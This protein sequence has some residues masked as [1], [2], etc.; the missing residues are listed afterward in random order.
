M[1]KLITTGL[2]KENLFQKLLTKDSV[3]VLTNQVFKCFKIQ[4]FK[5]SSF[6]LI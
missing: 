4:S 1:L 5:I 2:L 6:F 3:A